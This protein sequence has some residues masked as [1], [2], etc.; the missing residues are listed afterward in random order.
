LV[1]EKAASICTADGRL[2]TVEHAAGQL[3]DIIRTALEWPS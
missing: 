2:G 1:R 3:P